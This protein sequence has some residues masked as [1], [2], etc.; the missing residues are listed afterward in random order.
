MRGARPDAVV[1]LF[2]LDDDSRPLCVRV[3]LL[4]VFIASLS[5]S[6]GGWTGIVA[7]Y[8]N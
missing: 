7:F 4:A 3:V 6:L 8:L 2:D 1:A 5:P